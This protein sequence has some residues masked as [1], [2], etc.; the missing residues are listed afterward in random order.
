M[1]GCDP[2]FGAG[3]W[4]FAVPPDVITCRAAVGQHLAAVLA[5]AAHPAGDDVVMQRDSARS[6]RAASEIN[7]HCLTSG[8]TSANP[9]PGLEMGSHQPGV[10]AGSS[11]A[12]WHANPQM[13]RRPVDTIC[14]RTPLAGLSLRSRSRSVPISASLSAGNAAGGAVSANCMVAGGHRHWVMADRA[15]QPP[16]F[17]RRPPRRQHRRYH[18]G[19]IAAAAVA[20]I[21]VA[22]TVSDEDAA[23]TKVPGQ[24][25]AAPGN[26]QWERPPAAA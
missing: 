26:G 11:T 21:L 20:A 9:P 3:L 22:L 2:A 18:D 8:A 12:S 7:H 15:D 17:G 14:Y 6:R 24:P 1:A 16:R 19:S 4:I 10:A 5:D 25:R 23:A 13:R